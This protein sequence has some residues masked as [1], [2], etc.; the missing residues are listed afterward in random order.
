M[1]ETVGRT[2]LIIQPPEVDTVA[3]TPPLRWILPGRGRAFDHRPARPW[4][5]PAPR[6]AAAT[7]LIRWRVS[8]A[9]AIRVLG[10]NCMRATVSSRVFGACLHVV[11]SPGIIMWL[12]AEFSLERRQAELLAL[13]VDPR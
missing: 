7:R 6:A 3:H 9:T 8:E 4:D 1:I 5:P 2:L 10:R 12:A 13:A 11:S